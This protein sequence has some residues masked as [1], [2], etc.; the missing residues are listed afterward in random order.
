MTVLSHQPSGERYSPT[1]KN[2]PNDEQRVDLQFQLSLLY[3]PTMRYPWV[4]FSICGVWIATLAIVS[5]KIVD[6]T[7]I[8]V[9]ATVTV[10]TIFFLGFA[11]N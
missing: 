2:P 6:P 4:C 5:F 10:L 9:Y 7:T 3:N 1:L 11:R 8:Y